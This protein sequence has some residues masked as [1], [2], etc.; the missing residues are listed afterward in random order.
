MF[1]I[2]IPLLDIQTVQPEVEQELIHLHVQDPI[3][4]LGDLQILEHLRGLELRVQIEVGVQ[5]ML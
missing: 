4:L 1:V 5:E 3:P 2:E